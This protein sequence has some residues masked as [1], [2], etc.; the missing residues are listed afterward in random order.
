MRRTV[1]TS[2][3]TSITYIDRTPDGTYVFNQQIDKYNDKSKYLTGKKYLEMPESFENDMNTIT[4]NHG[5]VLI[6]NGNYGIVYDLFPKLE[7]DTA[8]TEKQSIK[9]KNIQNTES[10]YQIKNKQSYHSVVCKSNDNY[11]KP[12]CNI[13][14]SDYHGTIDMDLPSDYHCTSEDIYCQHG[15]YK[16]TKSELDTFYI[17]AKPYLYI[18]TEGTPEMITNKDKLSFI[19]CSNNIY[20]IANITDESYIEFKVK[21]SSDCIVEFM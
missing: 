17:K 15:L 2:V 7:K 10:H 13:I 16:F 4:T 20:Y 8:E 21:G 3:P 19:K 12:Q 9:L 11:L 18:S 6:Y 1:T 14:T 5:L